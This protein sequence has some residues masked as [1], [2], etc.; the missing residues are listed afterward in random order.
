[1]STISRL[2]PAATAATSLAQYAFGFVIG[3][4]I[5][6]ATFF[7]NSQD[8]TFL[9]DASAGNTTRLRWARNPSNVR[10]LFLHSMLSYIRFPRCATFSVQL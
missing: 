10:E 9:G 8:A 7:Y 2:T 1:M 6:T 4:T 3:A 5:G